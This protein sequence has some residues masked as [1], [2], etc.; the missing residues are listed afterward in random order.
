[1]LSA[2]ILAAGQ[3]RRLGLAVLKP[4]VKIAG[5][6]VIIY[7]LRTLDKHPR[8]DEIIVVVNAENQRVIKRLIRNYSFK[9]IKSFVLGGRRRQD[10]VYNGLKMVSPESDW[11]LIHDSA[12]PFIDGETIAKVILAAKKTG[13]AIVAVKPKATIKFSQKNNIVKETLDRNNLWEVQTP[14]VFKKEL[15]LQ[16]YRKYGKE[17]VTDDASLIE[18]SGEDVLIVQ[19][20]YQNIKITTG[21]DLLFAGL[22][23]KGRR[24]AV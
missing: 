23:A 5:L 21:E 1:M 10:S 11:V 13:S 14:Q 8:I 17:E 16:A 19:G 18:K 15:I 3:G 12:R 22:I 7:S 20:S 4:L 9:K 2:I 6:P 24:H